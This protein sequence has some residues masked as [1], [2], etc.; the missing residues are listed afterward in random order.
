M[1]AEKCGFV[2]HL[3][4]IGLGGCYLLGLALS[5]GSIDDAFVANMGV[6]ESSDLVWAAS[7]PIWN[8]YLP[9]A[10]L[11]LFLIAPLVYAL[12]NHLSAPS[13]Q[14]V[15]TV[16]DAPAFDF[17][18][19]S[20]YDSFELLMVAGRLAIPLTGGSSLALRLG[21]KRRPTATAA[22]PASR[23]FATWTWR[24]STTSFGRELAFTSVTS[25]HYNQGMHTVQEVDMKK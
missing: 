18:A 21:R 8:R 6:A 10:S 25:N 4:M 12:L 5:N 1:S 14:S 2:T 7:H 16:Q 3:L 15:S 22:P 9:T 17:R 13:P 11:G 23:P 19:K 24:S 20:R